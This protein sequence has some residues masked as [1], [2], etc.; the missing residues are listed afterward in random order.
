MKIS[1]QSRRD[2]KSLLN[3][4]RSGGLLD[5]NRVRAALAAV[6]QRKPRGYLG[7][8]T[9]FHRLVRLDIARRTALIESAEA[10]TPAFQSDVAANLT[11]KYGPGLTVSFTVNPSLIGG[12]RIKVGSD[13]LDGSVSARLQALAET[14]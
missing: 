2:G 12:L 10:L 3:A 8:L 1:K 14:F 5:E 13:V 9:H 4:C 6:V 7:T 11:K